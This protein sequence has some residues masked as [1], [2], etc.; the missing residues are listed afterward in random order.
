MCRLNYIV[1]LELCLVIHDTALRHRLSFVKYTYITFR[2]DDSSFFVPLF[3]GKLF[4][5]L[6]LNPD[7]CCVHVCG[8]FLTVKINQIEIYKLNKNV[9]RL[10]IDLIALRSVTFSLVN[11]TAVHIRPALE[12]YIRL[13]ILHKAWNKCL[14][15]IRLVHAFV[16]S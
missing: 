10:A 9:L 5:I 3:R 8:W 16:N 14:F 12:F 15:N 4:F 11:L 2:S 1:D 13:I 6:F 7:S